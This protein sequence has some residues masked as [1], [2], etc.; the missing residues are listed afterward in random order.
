M[1]EVIIGVDT[2]NRCIK[3]RNSVFLAGVKQFDMFP[4]VSQDIIT[5]NGKHYMLS[6]ERVSYL[7]DKTQTEEYFVMTL[8]A[9]MKEL[10]IRGIIPQKNNPIP[11]HLGVGLPPAHV[12]RLRERFIEYFDRGQICF[13]YNDEA[14]C[15][16]IMDVRLLAQGYAAIAGLP[17]EVKKY[18]HAYIIDIGGYTTDVMALERGAL[19]PKFCESFDYGVGGVL[20]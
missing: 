19:D 15:L 5:F 2:G 16:K 7:Q 12:S 9:I 17:G 20:K 6:S 18:P 1:E 10:R 11:V 8:F 14:V 4:A 3:T 13:R